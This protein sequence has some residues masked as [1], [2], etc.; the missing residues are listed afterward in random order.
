MTWA[1]A[2]LVAATVAG[3]EAAVVAM[4]ASGSPPLLYYG[5]Q[6]S[7]LIVTLASSIS[8]KKTQFL[9]MLASLLTLLLFIFHEIMFGLI[10]NFLVEKN[11]IK[12]VEDGT[13]YE[14]IYSII[15]SF[16]RYGVL[17][18]IQ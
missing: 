3:A 14:V 6:P 11:I 15:R 2:S 17:L 9:D 18:Y 5:S 13:L 10:I 4:V 8:E 1:V 7:F 12:F 16:K